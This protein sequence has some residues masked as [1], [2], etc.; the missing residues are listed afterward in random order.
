M[1]NPLLEAAD[2][3][4]RGEPWREELERLLRELPAEQAE[5][6]MML[7]NEGRGSFGLTLAGDGGEALLI[8]EALSGTAVGLEQLG[9]RVC[10]LS[11]EV[12]GL[13]IANGRAGGLGQ[14]ARLP[15]GVV[16]EAERLPFRDRAFDLVVHEGGPAV[17]WAAVLPELERVTGGELV[18]IGDN[19]LAYKRA[20]GRRGEFEH[21][22][23]LSLVA[24]WLRP[25]ADEARL[26]GYRSM[27]HEQG[28]QDLRSYALYPHA[29]EFSHVVGLDGDGPELTIGRREKQNRIKLWGKRLGLF[30]HFTPSF[31]VHGARR[32]RRSR[33]EHMLGA[34][35]ERTGLQ[36][37]P[38]EHLVATRSNTALVLTK[39][40]DAMS[41]HVPLCPAKHVLTEVHH[42]FLRRVAAEFP[43]VPVPEPLFVGVLEGT[44]LQAERRLGGMT[45]PHLT[46]RSAATD[47]LMG[48]LARMLA[49]LVVRPAEA[50]SLETFERLLG[51]RCREVQARSGVASTAR[52]LGRMLDEGRERLVGQRMPL[53]LYHAD[54]RAKHVQAEASGKII[55]MLD[56]GASE[57]EFLPM[58]DLGHFLL[59]QSKQIQGGTVGEAWQRLRHRDALAVAEQDALNEYG[60][61]LGLERETQAALLDLVPLFVAGMAERN[62]DYSR[63]AWVHRQF[64]L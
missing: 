15:A 42:E 36:P 62:W 5:E 3:L 14:A 13:R 44:W 9:Y 60:S 22:R 39:G 32:S 2:A 52:A 47:T 17:G 21:A 55:G 7:L 59:H 18:L 34:L 25:R 48:E 40:P 57:S 37:G 27:L 43:G 50:L 8:G 46:G 4:D 6:W 41:V 1:T 10:T 23:P 45:A 54:T 16:A 11:D 33:M 12:L 56:W 31:C 49:L 29:R 38:V 63:P 26:V 30:A 20:L 61:A 24:R 51:E 53:M 28:F 64:G 35:A 58:A 19:P